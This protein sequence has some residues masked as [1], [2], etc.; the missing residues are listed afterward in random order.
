MHARD[1]TAELWREEFGEQCEHEPSGR[2]TDFA[3][4][5][6]QP[7]L[8]DGPELIQNNLARLALESNRHTGGIR[9]PLRS[10]GGYND[11]IDMLIHFV[12][13]D[14]ETGASLADFT[15]LGGIKPH[16]EHIESGGYHVHSFRSHVEAEGDS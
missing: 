10:H 3:H 2:F 13:R 5:F 14:H 6:D 7:A 15:A 9:A 12:R 16:E 1:K 4:A 8:I 11:G